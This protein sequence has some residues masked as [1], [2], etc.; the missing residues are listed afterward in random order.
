V[1]KQGLEVVA[2]R[3][4]SGHDEVAHFS[5]LRTVATQGRVPVLPDLQTWRATVA[6]GREANID[7]LP[8]E[9]YPYCRY[10]LDWFCQPEKLQWALHPPH[11][12]T[13]LGAYYPSGYQYAAN[14][15]PLYY[16]LMTPVYWASQRFSVETQQYL[17]RLAAIPLGLATVWLA[18]L[19]TRA[20][21]PGDIFLAVTVPTFV[22]LQP[23][24]SYEAAMVN[25]DI[26][27]IA[28]YSWILYL[29]V[30]GLRDRFPTRTCVL[31]GFV[32][33]L[34]LLAK[35]TSSTAAPIIALAI[36][37]G[38]GW[39]NIRDWLR[40]GALVLVPAAILAAPWYAF[41][42]HTYGNFDGLA[43]VERL[44]YWNRPAG[45]FMGMLF[46]RDFIVMRFKETWGE[47]GWRLIHL[48]PTLLWAIAIPLIV[49]VAGLV[50][51]LVTARRQPSSPVDPVRHP[52][53]WQWQALIVLAA[54]C[55]VAYLAVIQ[56]G[57][58]FALTQARYYFPV[59]NAASLL[60]MLGLR[61]VVPRRYH[62]Y[63]QGIV[64]AALIVLNVVIF[65][66]YVIPHYLSI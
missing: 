52:T 39:R 10:T 25:N 47:F 11:M 29:L 21:F 63:A 24:I 48:T 23:Q 53:R 57:T 20:L 2:F 50:L 26:L 59:V 42:Y 37:L 19:L 34:A 60:L 54:T 58:Q 4:F 64:F 31:L 28:L 51:Y 44:Q 36:V 45:T 14:H 43:Q 32:F 46:S 62:A 22:A 38:S 40:R 18:L 55:V 13:L 49:A 1:L 56:F 5:Y 3:P 33:G 6:S 16:L 7:L 15:P 9:L 66:Q 41:L 8:D 12:V 27:C 65:T 35:G 30:V 61:T 17:L